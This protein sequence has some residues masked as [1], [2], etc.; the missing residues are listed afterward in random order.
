MSEQSGFTI[1]LE[2]EQDY[3]F[4]AS[5][6]LSKVPELGLDAGEP[7]G[8]SK[9]PDSERLVA[10]A[11]GYCLSASLL[12]SMRKFKQNPGKLRAE[13]SGTFARNERGRLRVGGFEVMIRLSDP[14][15]QI[16]HFERAGQQFEDFCTVTESIREGIPV[17]VQV[18]DGTGRTVHAS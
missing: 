4:K 18:V 5:F 14:A 15:E 3:Q 11:V 13:V 1:K 16:S 8:Q 7:L 6:D 9:G 10:V 12:F 17:R 2:Q